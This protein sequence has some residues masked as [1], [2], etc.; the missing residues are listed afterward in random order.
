MN[1][2][3]KK[4]N[5]P[6]DADLLAFHSLSLH[7]RER[8]DVG[9]PSSGREKGRTASAAVAEDCLGSRSPAVRQDSLP[10]CWLLLPRLVAL[11]CCC[12]P[13]VPSHCCP[14]VGLSSQGSQQGAWRPP[15][16][17]SLLGCGGS[18]VR[19]GRGGA[20]LSALARP[21]LLT[22]APT[23]EAPLLAAASH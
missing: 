8:A 1:P 23:R 6:V 18:Y 20:S 11:L 9:K 15:A 14:I 16:G 13:P 4:H 3:Q 17:M 7:R 22:T 21:L 12:Q 2:T 5:P 10:L 19:G